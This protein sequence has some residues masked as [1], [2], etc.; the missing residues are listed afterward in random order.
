MR[1]DAASRELNLI[2][3]KQWVVNPQRVLARLL[4]YGGQA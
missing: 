1:A 3:L 2:K 4:L